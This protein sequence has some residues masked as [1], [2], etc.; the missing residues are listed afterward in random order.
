MIRPEAVYVTPWVADKPR[1]RHLPDP[2]HEGARS[3]CGKAD[4]ITVVE[5]ARRRA[6]WQAHSRRHRAPI[7]YGALPV[8]FFCEKAS[9]R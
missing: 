7:R 3:L 6:V 1:V 4:V 5:H 8:C 2:A 9:A